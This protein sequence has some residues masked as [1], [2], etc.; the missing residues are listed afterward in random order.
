MEIE[1]YFNEGSVITISN[2]QGNNTKP[3]TVTP[4]KKISHYPTDDTMDENQFFTIYKPEDLDFGFEGVI[5]FKDPKNIITR[6]IINPIKYPEIYKDYNFEDNKA[7]LLYGAPG[8]G[9]TTFAQ[10]IAK[11][12]G[13]ALYYISSASIVSKYVGDSSKHIEALFTQMRE[14]AEKYMKENNTGIIAFFDEFDEIAKRTDDDK[15]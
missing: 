6:Y 15:A 1:N 10:A 8:T 3:K 14:D 11:E 2:G 7:V 13:W 5:G 12:T 4:N 9:K